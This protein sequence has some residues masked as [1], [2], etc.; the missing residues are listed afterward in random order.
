MSI[1]FNKLLRTLGL[2]VA[3]LA[4]APA[5]LSGGDDVLYQVQP[6]DTLS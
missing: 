6:G 4:T 1:V 2:T 5:A 3:L